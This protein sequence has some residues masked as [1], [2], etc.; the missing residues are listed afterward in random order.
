[1]E[2][3][4]FRRLLN[5]DRAEEE[6]R[7]LH[8]N[9]LRCLALDKITYKDIKGKP[10][11]EVKDRVAAFRMIYPEG[12]ITSKIVELDDKHAV[13]RAEVLNDRGELLATGYASETFGSSNINRTSM[14]EN[15]ETSAVGRALGF[16]GIGI[17]G[18]IASAQEIERAGAIKEGRDA[19][20]ICHRCGR[21]IIDTA[22]KSGKV[23]AAY[24][25]A[26]MTAKT[27]GDVFCLP[28]VAEIKKAKTEAET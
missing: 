16:L 6:A 11:A 10:Y 26:K 27:Y 1:M 20:Q 23:W 15:C 19:F 24:D 5:P 14:L 17:Q 18:A 28:C 9:N 8:V 12:T 7:E 4:E 22:D 3:S 2:D 13:I 21:Q 25:I